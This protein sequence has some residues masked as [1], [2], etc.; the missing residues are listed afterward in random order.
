MELVTLATAAATIFFVKVIEKP[1]ENLGQFVWDKA[2]N[3]AGRLIGESEK[4]AG[5]LEA[6]HQ[7]PVNVGEVLIELKALEEKYPEIAQDMK[8]LATEADKESNPQLKQKI[9]EFRDEAEKLKDEDQQLTIQNNSKLAEEIGV[10]NQGVTQ[11]QPNYNINKSV[12]E[13]QHNYNIT[14]N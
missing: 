13:N 8:E 1:G 4:L 7:Q 2:Q 6:S 14:N 3:L 10:V 9:Q 11:N 12:I 5:L